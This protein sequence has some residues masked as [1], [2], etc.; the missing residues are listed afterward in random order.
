MKDKQLYLVHLGY[1]DDVSGGVY[2]CHTNAFVAASSFD[3]AR[4]QAKEPGSVYRIGP[5]DNTKHESDTDDFVNN[6]AAII[7]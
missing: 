6:T 2:E 4:A 1:Y 5:R 3:D 7:P